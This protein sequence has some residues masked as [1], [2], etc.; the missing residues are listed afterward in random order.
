ME[1]YVLTVGQR[2]R[3]LCG[4]G[5]EPSSHRGQLGLRSCEIRVA[6][7]VTRYAKQGNETPFML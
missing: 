6:V 7:V 3:N 1:A 2:I 5:K 4:E